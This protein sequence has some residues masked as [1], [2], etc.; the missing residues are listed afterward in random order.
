MIKNSKNLKK[1][2][3]QQ[4]FKKLKKLKNNN[5]VHKL[6]SKNCNFDRNGSVKYQWEI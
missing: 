2:K 4:K 5:P 1:F 3:K 6:I